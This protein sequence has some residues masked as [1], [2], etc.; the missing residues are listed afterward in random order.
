MRTVLETSLVA[1]A[2]KIRQKGNTSSPLYWPNGFIQAVNE[3][4]VG[5]GT[6]WKSEFD[7]ELAGQSAVLPAAAETLRNFCFYRRS[8]ITDMS[9]LT[10]V[11]NIGNSCFRYAGLTKA[12][13]PVAET[14]G[15]YAF[16]ELPSLGEIVLTAAQ[17]LGNYCFQNS[18]TSALELSLPACT[19]IGQDCF[20]GATL[21]SISVP[22]LSSIGQEAF[23]S[24]TMTGADLVFPSTITST[25]TAML[26]Q[27]K[28]KTCTFEGN[29][30][31][32]GGN[33]FYSA[34]GY[35]RIRFPNNTQVPTVGSNALYGIPSTARIVVPDALY[36]TW[37]TATGWTNYASKIIKVSQDV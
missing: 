6:N 25:P 37:R 4:D 12:K 23:L 34:S 21:K 11:L 13:F 22:S 19:S 18:G 26:R 5:G 28:F 14:V 36:D 8:D 20:N 7:K 1:L 2:N 24:A 33:T 31:A 27:A 32:L 9:S 30:T 35:T 3:M 15:N 17:S 10:A 29:I 16:A